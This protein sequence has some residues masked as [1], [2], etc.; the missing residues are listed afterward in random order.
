MWL[1]SPNSDGIKVPLFDIVIPIVSG[2][3]SGS[4]MVTYR[5]DN[6]EAAILIRNIRQSVT[7]WF[8][9]YWTH[10]LKYKHGVIKKLMKSFDID[11]AKLT[12]LS[13]FGVAT[14]MVYTE[15]GN[16]DEQLEHIKANLGTNQWFAD[17]EEV[18]GVKMTISGNKEALAQTLRDPVDNIDNA[19]RN[20]PS[21]RI[22]FSCLTGNSTNNSEATIWQHTL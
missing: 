18:G 9:G 7:S 11:M 16:V 22:N 19:D 12:G 13:T 1:S 2:I 3:Q 21:W 5:N 6:R 8:Y 15:Y 17:S 10:V 4:A 14:L 20:G